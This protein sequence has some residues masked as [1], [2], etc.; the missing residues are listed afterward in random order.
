VGV[1]L[2][3]G[4]GFVPVGGQGAGERQVASGGEEG[5]D[6][7]VVELVKAL[8]EPVRAVAA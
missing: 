6:V 8:G 5:G 2:E 7:A 4:Q 3:V 1:G